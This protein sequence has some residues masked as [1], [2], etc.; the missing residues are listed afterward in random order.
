MT[1]QK[2]EKA[3]NTGKV[4]R[5]AEKETQKVDNQKEAEVM[6]ITGSI[7][8]TQSIAHPGLALIQ[9]RA[10]HHAHAH[11]RNHHAAAPMA[12]LDAQSAW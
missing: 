6:T 8:K 2:Q 1:R 12:H 10:L 11:Q 5:R 7:L 9:G 3:E 4:I